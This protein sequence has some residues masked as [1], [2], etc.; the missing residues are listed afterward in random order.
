VV[1]CGVAE[2]R[3]L[4]LNCDGQGKDQYRNDDANNNELEQDV[5]AL[6]IAD[7]PRFLN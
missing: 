1:H 3:R 7:P 6:G 5:V 2:K 4:T